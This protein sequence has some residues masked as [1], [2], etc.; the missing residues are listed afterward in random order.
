[1]NGQFTALTDKA[2]SP[3]TDITFFGGFSGQKTPVNQ[4][5]GYI[6]DD[7]SW[8][9]RL[10]L[11]IG[12]RYDY[13]AGFDLDQRANPIWQTLSTQT[14]YNEFFLRDFQGGR[15]GKLKNDNNNYAPRLGFTWDATGNGRHLVRGGWGIYYDFPYTNATILFPAGAVQ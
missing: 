14:K 7:I 9:E 6:Q 1:T 11:N 3:I 13:W 8:S 4:Y 10:T 5:S 12:L 2:S 15:G